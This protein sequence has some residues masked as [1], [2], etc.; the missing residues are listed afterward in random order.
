MLHL[1]AHPVAYCVHT[2]GL[3]LNNSQSIFCSVMTEVQHNYV[4][5]ICTTRPTLLGLRTCISITVHRSTQRAHVGFLFELICLT[6]QKLSKQNNII[7][8]VVMVEE[9]VFLDDIEQ[10]MITPPRN[11]KKKTRTKEKGKTHKRYAR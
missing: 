5:S 6:Y 11:G 10:E 7:V 4:T 2:F 9:E 1:F 3:T 8:I